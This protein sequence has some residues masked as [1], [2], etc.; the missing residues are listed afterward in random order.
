MSHFS[1]KKQQ[2]TELLEEFFDT[3]KKIDKQRR[4]V[5][6]KN[7]TLQSNPTAQYYV[8][9]ALSVIVITLG[10]LINSESVVIGGMLVAPLLPVLQA[11]SLSSV[12][13]SIRLFHRALSTLIVTFFLG[14][15]LSFFVTAIIPYN[16]VSEAIIARTQPDF[17]FLIIALAAGLIGAIDLIWPSV[18]SLAAGVMVATA[19]VPPLAVVGIG[20]AKLDWE[21]M[22]Q[23]F[24]LFFTNLLAVVFAGIILLLVAGFRPYHRAESVELLW[25]N[26]FWSFVLLLV[27]TIPLGAALNH[28]AKLEEQN[29]VV[30]NNLKEVLGNQVEVE[31][32]NTSSIDEN[33]LKIEVRLLSKAEPTFLQ[34]DELVNRLENQLE[35][36]ILLELNTIVISQQNY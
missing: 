1:D 24:I 12:R 15:L 2:T 34:W 6:T 21:I 9:V 19:L 31:K 16:G 10:L 32:I 23:S 26:I 25:K 22:S 36:K 27:V 3:F 18:G 17:L 11:L 30:T 13:G 29:I 4:K 33:L 14:V 7:I 28:T 5:I 8:L 35:R 20:L